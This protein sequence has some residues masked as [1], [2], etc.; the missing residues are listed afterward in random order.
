MIQRTPHVLW[1]LPNHSSVLAID[2]QPTPMI[3][4]LLPKA[5]F[6]FAPFDSKGSHPTLL[7]PGTPHTFTVPTSPYPTL[8]DAIWTSS[9]PQFLD[10]FRSAHRLVSDGTLQKFVLAS[11][12][13]M[14]QDLRPYA[15]SLFDRAC[16]AY[17]DAFVALVS[18]PN[19]DMWLMATPELLVNSHGDMLHTMALAGTQCV[20]GMTWDS[21]NLREHNVVARFV[22]SRLRSLT[23]ITSTSGPSTVHAGTLAHLKT[24]FRAQMPQGVTAW[25]VARAL[26]PTPAMS[27][28]PQGEA[29]E[30]IRRVETTDREYFSGM[31]GVFSPNG[32]ADIYVTIRC[33]RLSEA[34]VRLYS[35]VGLMPD[36]DPTAEAEESAAKRL[37][38]KN[39]IS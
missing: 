23:S 18:L 9:L 8:T 31:S 4:N 30:A 22:E 14:S 25:D 36:S 1:R 39:I 26:H 37:T 10:E 21:K 33:M 28:M 17:R 24:D 34:G 29:V 12:E 35:G 7:F 32:D 2:A 11:H 3:G 20:D 38:M 27:G 16:R 13:D 19:R 5:G 6:I 15:L